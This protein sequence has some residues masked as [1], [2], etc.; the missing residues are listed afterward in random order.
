MAIDADGAP[1]AYHPLDTG[2]DALAN[3]GFPS[4]GWRNVLVEDPKSPGKPFVQ[5]R[6]AFKGYFIA[7]TTLEDKKLSAT[8]SNRYV[9]STSIPYMVFPGAFHK[10]NG[11]GTFG[12][13]GIVRNL[14]N[15]KVSAFIVADLGL[16]NAPLGEVSIQ[17]AVNLGGSNV[18]PRTGSGMPK[19]PFF[20]VLFPNT[21]FS[22]PW[23]ISTA[24]LNLH[25]NSLL[26]SI[27][28]WANILPCIP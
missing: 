6:G 24:T 17:L 28:G 16:S 8:D 20:Y 4:G 7:K 27:G 12:D 26:N 3:A 23:P 22:I 11:T 2:I 19:G 1:I 25:S 10:I 13:L 18:N 15:G 9:D 14:K 21:K 5:T